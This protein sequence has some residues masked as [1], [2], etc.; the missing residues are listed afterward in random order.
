[1]PQAAVRD[2]VRNRTRIGE[3]GI[4]SDAMRGRVAMVNVVVD[5]V[6][7]AGEVVQLV[8]YDSRWVR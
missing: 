1:M 8:W 7:V 3:S 4:M 5:V 2:V 6:E